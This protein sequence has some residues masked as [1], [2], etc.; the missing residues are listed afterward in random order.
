MRNFLTD[1]AS[2]N[3]KFV[4]TILDITTPQHYV[5]LKSTKIR[6]FF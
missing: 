2:V 1:N 3:Y 6:P 5:P 4:A